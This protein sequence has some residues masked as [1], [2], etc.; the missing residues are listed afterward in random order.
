MKEMTRIDRGRERERENSEF[1]ENIQ[2]FLQKLR[3]HI[4][5]NTPHFLYKLSP[6]EILKPLP[7]NK[8]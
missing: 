2:F 7:Y 3:V 5:I 1:R 6:I 8:Y 4:F